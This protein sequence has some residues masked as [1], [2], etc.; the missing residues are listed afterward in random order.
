MTALVLAWLAHI[1]Y[2]RRRRT[3]QLLPEC[4]CRDCRYSD[5]WAFELQRNADG[6]VRPWEVLAFLESPHATFVDA[7]RRVEDFVEQILDRVVLVQK[8]LASQASSQTRG[9]HELPHGRV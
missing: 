6:V 7:D 3:A 1:D 5:L 9:I 2:Q 4:P 8:M